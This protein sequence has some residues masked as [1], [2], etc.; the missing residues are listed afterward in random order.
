MLGSGRVLLSGAGRV[1]PD[2]V[3]GVGRAVIWLVS[4]LL[5]DWLDESAAS[6]CANSLDERC[7]CWALAAFRLSIWVAR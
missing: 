7:C 2:A 5:V 4:Q 1:L 6:I 3:S